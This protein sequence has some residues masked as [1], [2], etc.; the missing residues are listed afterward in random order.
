LKD[1]AAL[2]ALRVVFEAYADLGSSTSRRRG[3]VGRPV[4]ATVFLAQVWNLFDCP[5]E[6]E[7][8]ASNAWEGTITSCGDMSEFI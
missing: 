1:E 4:E 8:M 6:E 3:F 7:L 2:D 5:L